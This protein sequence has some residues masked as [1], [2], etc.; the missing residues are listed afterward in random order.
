MKGGRA[1]KSASRCV[2]AERVKPYVSR[3]GGGARNRRRIFEI[4]K[5]SPGWQRRASITHERAVAVLHPATRAHRRVSRDLVNVPRFSFA[6]GRELSSFVGG[7]IE[8]M[9]P[10]AFSHVVEGDPSS[11]KTSYVENATN[12]FNKDVPVCVKGESTERIEEL[13]IRILMGLNKHKQ[14]KVNAQPRPWASPRYPISPTR[15][16]T[17]ARALRVVASLSRLY[18]PSTM[19]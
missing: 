16:S 12:L 19:R 7:E 1:V 11:W 8:K 5:K 4:S 6:I 10:A 15:D 17:P 2:K 13:T 18:S 9:S 3:S 14:S